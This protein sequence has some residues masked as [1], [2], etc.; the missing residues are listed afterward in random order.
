MA[1]VGSFELLI[2]I[3]RS[4]Q[5]QA[6]GGP[7]IWHEVDP[8]QQRA[9]EFF[10]ELLAADRVPSICAIPAQF[11]IGQERVQRLRAHLDSEG[12]KQG[13]ELAA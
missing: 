2:M 12:R 11:H 3:I 7:E 4:S 13:E 5:V 6:N 10:A 8:L 9:A 1:L